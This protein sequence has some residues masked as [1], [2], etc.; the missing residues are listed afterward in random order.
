MRVHF[1]FLQE[2]RILQPSSKEEK[3]KFVIALF[4]AL[5]LI[6]YAAAAVN[7]PWAHPR[8]SMQEYKLGEEMDYDLGYDEPGQEQDYQGNTG[9]GQ[10]QQIIQREMGEPTL[11][12]GTCTTLANT[13]TSLSHTLRGRGVLKL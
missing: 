2:R 12:N 8:T 4:L 3:M 11:S 9:F 13:N 1:L 6:G 7:V 5:A 10:M